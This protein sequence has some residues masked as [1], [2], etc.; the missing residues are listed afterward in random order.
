MQIVAHATFSID[1]SEIIWSPGWNWFGAFLQKCKVP[2]HIYCKFNILESAPRSTCKYQSFTNSDKNSDSFWEQLDLIIL[3]SLTDGKLNRRVKIVMS[4]ML[5][6][7]C[8]T[9]K[10]KVKVD[11]LRW[12]LKQKL[13]FYA[14]SWSKRW[15]STLKVKVKVD[16]LRWKLRSRLL[17]LRNHCL[18]AFLILFKNV[19]I[20]LQL[21]CC[22]LVNRQA[23]SSKMRKL[24][25]W[26]AY[27]VTS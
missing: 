14:E 1:W 5:I 3:V 11:V 23:H 13:M 2:T 10:V 18:L 15:C 27:K 16:V 20:F 17:R 25:S 26:Q 19:L 4:K 8:S 24:K 7:W 21:K 22:I 12:K 9:L 6:S